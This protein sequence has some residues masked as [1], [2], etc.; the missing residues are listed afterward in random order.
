[1]GKEEP[2]AA[3]AA[4]IGLEDAPLEDELLD[5]Y[6]IG[7]QDFVSK[8]PGVNSKNIRVILNKGKSLS[9]LLTLSQEELTEMLG[10]KANAELLF[11]AL[12]ATSAESQDASASSF[13]AKP[14]NRP[15][16]KR[17]RNN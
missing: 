10:N 13:R 5:K 12:H 7:I 14:K 11:N 9:H 8:L 16:R 17:A 3:A 2:S 6:N 4:A 1:E 15:F